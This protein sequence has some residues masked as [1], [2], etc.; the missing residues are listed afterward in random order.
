MTIISDTLLSQFNE[1]FEQA[2]AH[3]HIIDP[4]AATLA[5]VG[6]D[7]MP[8]ARIVLFRLI[9]ARGFAFFTNYESHKSRE[10][11]A[12]RQAAIC[13]HWV[14][15]EKQIRVEGS[16]EKVSA[17]ESDAYFARRHR[18]SQLGA[19]A[20]AQSQPLVSRDD[21]LG[22]VGQM[23]IK[24]EGGEVPRPPHWG[25]WRIVPRAIEFWQAGEFRLHDRIR[26]ERKADGSW[27]GM[28]LNP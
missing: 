8:S 22:K 1:W 14:P 13:F 28:R 7:G 17:E 27:A 20:S 24:F 10:L 4:D 3:P 6:K 11:A 5:T 26:Y 18:E 15:L 19:W 9:D 12:H 23:A 2:K 21:L 16:V 25:G